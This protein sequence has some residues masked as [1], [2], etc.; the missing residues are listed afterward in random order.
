MHFDAA[1][2]RTQGLL[3]ADYVK[4]VL[5]GK[6]L[7]SDLAAAAR[8]SKYFG[9]YCPTAVRWT[10]RPAHLPATDLTFAFEPG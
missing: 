9:Q 3:L 6:E 5:R 4:S 1:T 10:C 7:P 8:E 2:G